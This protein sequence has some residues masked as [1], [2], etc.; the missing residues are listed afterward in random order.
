MSVACPVKELFFDHFTSRSF[1][2]ESRPNL[3]IR[4]PLPVGLPETYQV[5]RQDERSTNHEMEWYVIMRS[6]CNAIAFFLLFI[7]PP[8]LAITMSILAES[9]RVHPND[10]DV[11]GRLVQIRCG[12][13]SVLVFLPGMAEIMEVRNSK[14]SSDTMPALWFHRHWI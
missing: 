11:V 14:I 1:G 10:R 5:F 3:C 8:S 7:N 13:R 9:E 12:G 2:V 4:F 6:M